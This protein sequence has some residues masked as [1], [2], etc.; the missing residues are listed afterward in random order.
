METGGLVVVLVWVVS[1]V[2]SVMVSVMVLVVDCDGGGRIISLIQLCRSVTSS[3][4]YVG[5]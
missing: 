1:M 5:G 3:C 4:V 2:V